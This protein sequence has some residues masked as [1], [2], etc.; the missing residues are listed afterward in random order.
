MRVIAGSLSG[1]QFEAPSARSVHPMG[2]KVRGALF[3]A[4]GD[5]EGLTVLDAFAG[6]GALGIEAISR[7]AGPV[8]AIDNDKSAQKAIASNI[9]SLQLRGRLKLIKASAGAWL[10]TSD[11][12]FDLVLLDPPYHDLQPELL[13]KLAAR[14]TNLVVLSLP[15]ASDFKLPA[16]SYQLLANKSYGD[17]TLVFYRRRA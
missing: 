14:S 10:R 2:E 8:T 9:R 17:A 3:N 5:I 6:S 15:P 4:L 13:S 11:N 1:R 7:S 16:I 12:Q